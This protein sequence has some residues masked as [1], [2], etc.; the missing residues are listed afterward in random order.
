[1]INFFDTN[2][3]IYA[4]INQDE[5][6]MLLSQKFIQEAVLE[7]KLIISPLILQ[8][9]VFTLKKLK[10][11]TIEINEKANFFLKYCIHEIDC[12]V[13]KNALSLAFEINY[14]QN[15]NDI[16][17]LKFAENYANKLVTFDSDFGRLKPFTKL[18]IQI[19]KL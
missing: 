15:I 9:Y 10:L 12:N 8:E 5:K 18:D 2:I 1:M 6:K 17:H 4:T 3:F 13:F 7:N 11:N 16:I 19:L 14:F